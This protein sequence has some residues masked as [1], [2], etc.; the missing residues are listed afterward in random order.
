MAAGEYELALTDF[1]I[2]LQLD[3]T[4]VNALLGREQALKAANNRKS[5]RK[6]VRRKVSKPGTQPGTDPSDAASDPGS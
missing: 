1:A 6:P 4:N 5:G 2:V 3:P